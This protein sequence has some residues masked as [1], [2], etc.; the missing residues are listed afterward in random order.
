MDLS[1]YNPQPMNKT[2]SLP[3]FSYPFHLDIRKDVIK[4]IN[5][6]KSQ[7]KSQNSYIYV[8][9]DKVYLDKLCI[10]DNIYMCVCVCVC[11]L[12]IIYFK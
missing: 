10:I 11:V 1:P 2:K 3:L 9:T 7:N 6:I 8:F 12:L 5:K 4:L